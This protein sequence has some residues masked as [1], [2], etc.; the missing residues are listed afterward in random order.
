MY[1][2]AL[3]LNKN[4][5]QNGLKDFQ[6]VIYSLL[7]NEKNFLFAI[8]SKENPKT[9]SLLSRSSIFLFIKS[10]NIVQRI[11]DFQSLEFL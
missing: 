11:T 10:N 9:W 3:L 1:L 6:K 2:Q 8:F 4:Y 7:L 5:K